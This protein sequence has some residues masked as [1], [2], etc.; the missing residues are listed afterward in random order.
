MT[1][2]KPLKARIHTLSELQLETL[3]L[4]RK[5]RSQLQRSAHDPGLSDTE[6]LDKIVQP[7]QDKIYK[8][9]QMAKLLKEK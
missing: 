4:I 3:S 7:L 8:D 5:F 9:R 6:F 1:K 2:V